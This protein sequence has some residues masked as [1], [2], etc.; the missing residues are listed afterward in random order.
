LEKLGLK[1]DDKS[2]PTTV[3]K[4]NPAKVEKEEAKL[5]GD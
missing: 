4:Q 5:E 1:G 3:K 2:N